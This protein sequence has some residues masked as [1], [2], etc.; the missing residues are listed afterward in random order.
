MRQLALEGHEGQKFLR[1]HWP[2]HEKLK[3]RGGPQMLLQQGQFISTGIRDRSASQVDPHQCITA[4]GALALPLG[5]QEVDTFVPMSHAGGQDRLKKDHHIVIVLS[6][7]ACQALV[8]CSLWRLQH[9]ASGVQQ[10]SQTAPERPGQASDRIPVIARIG[11]HVVKERRRGLFAAATLGAS[12]K[13]L[14]RFQ[15][16]VAATYL[17]NQGMFITKRLPLPSSQTA[18]VDIPAGPFALARSDQLLHRGFF[19]TEAALRHMLWATR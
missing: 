18:L 16:K 10:W 5:G 13:L 3:R 9:E 17:A 12:P 1:T 8:T 15:R 6:P 11:A 2:S 7:P 19:Q 14:H 4:I